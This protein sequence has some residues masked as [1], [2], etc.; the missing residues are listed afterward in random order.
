M[1]LTWT[2][3]A[4]GFVL[5]QADTITSPV[6]WQSI[7]TPATPNGAD[8]TVTIAGSAGTRFFRLRQD[9]TRVRA[10]SPVSGE[11]GVAVTRETIVHFTAPLS[12]NTV[13]GTND[14]YAT[15]GGR[16]F[17]SRAELSSDRTKATLFY[18]EP[19]PGSARIKV[20]LDGNALKDTAGMPV[21]ADADGIPGGQAVISFDTLSLSTLPGT[22]VIGK[23]FAS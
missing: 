10:S 12:T 17:L 19:L 13:I 23:V 14:F 18:L 3:T 7:A 8:F 5:E 2:N 1:Q 20:V 15:F 16:R 22:A 4:T 11:T 21:D 6:K 9:L